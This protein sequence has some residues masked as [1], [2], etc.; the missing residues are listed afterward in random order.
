MLNNGDDLEFF[1]LRVE[2]GLRKRL[3]QVID[4][5]FKRLPYTEA[6][7]IL[8]EHIKGKK[9][10]FENKVYWGCDLASEHEKYLTDKVF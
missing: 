9:V 10:K 1:D 4:T 2:K 6:V 7:T 3:Q 8:E 5:P